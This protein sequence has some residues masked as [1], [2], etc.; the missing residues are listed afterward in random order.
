[1]KKL[2]LEEVP[3][4]A[5]VTIP[6]DKFNFSCICLWSR[7]TCCALWCL[8]REDLNAAGQREGGPIKEMSQRTLSGEETS[9][10]HSF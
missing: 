1:M 9:Q 5:P 10:A 6:S 7:L 3:L 8:H 2:R 4:S